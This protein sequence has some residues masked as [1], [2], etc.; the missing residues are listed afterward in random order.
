MLAYWEFVKLSVRRQITY[1]AATL[2]GLLTNVFFGLIRAAVM[3]ALFGAGNEVAG[4]TVQDAITF[5]GLTQA[6]IAYL[7]L[8]NWY[9]VVN[10]VRSGQIGTELLK[11]LDYFTYWMTQD[12]GRATVS[13]VSRGFTIMAFYAIIFDIT[14]PTSLKQW[15]AFIVAIILAW[16]VSFAR[17]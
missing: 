10:S 3:V 6:S 8:F 15:L 13:L 2:A 14:V 1:R 7:S 12:L 11:P 4:M 5:T 16:A 17:L 9:E